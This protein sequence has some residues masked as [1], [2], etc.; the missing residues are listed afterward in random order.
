[1]GARSIVCNSAAGPGVIS[2]LSLRAIWASLPRLQSP[3]YLSPRP[4]TRVVAWL[5][6]APGFS[7][8][9]QTCAPGHSSD[10][11]E[12]CACLQQSGNTTDG[13]DSCGCRPCLGEG[14]SSTQGRCSKGSETSSQEACSCER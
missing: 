8:H 2:A 9:T 6:Q 3:R 12:A 1:M 4:T 10:K 14:W 5:C 13:E 7:S 11:Q